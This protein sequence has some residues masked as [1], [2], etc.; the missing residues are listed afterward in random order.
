M[1]MSKRIYTIEV[2]KPIN[3]ENISEIM[4]ITN[5]GNS[6][7]AHIL[8]NINSG[9][10]G[11]SYEICLSNFVRNMEGFEK[12][13]N[14][15]FYIKEFIE[16]IEHFQNITLDL[17]YNHLTNEHMH[18]ILTVL[19]NDKLNLLRLKLVKINIEHN[20]LSKQG[21]SEIFQFINNCPNF[22]ELEASINLLGQ[23]NY[24]ELKESGEVPKCIKDTFFYQSF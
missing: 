3:E 23:T 12:L 11:T 13:C 20:R 24:F 4:V 16:Y 1:K 19:S 17:S 10:D 6:I 21:F 15:N 14:I 9:L 8:Q 18:K 22:K 2:D 5:N 7:R